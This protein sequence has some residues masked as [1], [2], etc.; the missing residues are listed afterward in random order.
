M[1]IEKM[2]VA[3]KYYLGKTGKIKISELQ[4]N[5]LFASVYAEI[6]QSG[7]QMTGPMAAIYKTWDT[8]N[9]SCDLM[10]AI[11]VAENT[12]AGNLELFKIPERTAVVGIYQGPYDNLKGAH[13][14]MMDFMNKDN[15]QSDLA[16]EEYLN[17][18]ENT[19]P[20]NLLTRIVHYL[21]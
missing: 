15:L 8:A 10:P 14:E 3:P 20:E 4:G 11:L 1:K 21:K 7:A 6:T 2:T 18:P 9:N 17:N 12:A 5:P 16:V 19:A 13:Q